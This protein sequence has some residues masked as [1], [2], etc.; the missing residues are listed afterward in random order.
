MR[1]FI[2]DFDDPVHKVE[3]DGQ[4]FCSNVFQ[5]LAERGESF[6]MDQTVTTEIYALMADMSKMSVRSSNPLK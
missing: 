6:E 4:P 3:Q 1:Y 2:V 5:N